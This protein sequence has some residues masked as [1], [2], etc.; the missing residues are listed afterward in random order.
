MVL[1]LHSGS[2][3]GDTNGDIVVSRRTNHQTRRI[4][5]NDANSQ[6]RFGLVEHARAFPAPRLPPRV[7]PL[8]DQKGRPIIYF[9]WQSQ[10]VIF[11]GFLSMCYLFCSFFLST[12]AGMG[13]LRQPASTVP[14]L[15][16]VIVLRN[17]NASLFSCCPLKELEL[18]TTA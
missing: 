4:S 7:G 15:S 12:C 17:V 11:G 3:H 6:S 2:W 1:I 16:W 10:P 13:G 14:A 18:R 5:I 9:W 8:T